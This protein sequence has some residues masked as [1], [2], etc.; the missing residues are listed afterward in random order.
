[1]STHKAIKL[2]SSLRNLVPILKIDAMFTATTTTSVGCHLSKLTIES[3]SNT[4][5]AVPGPTTTI[6]NIY[7][8]PIIESSCTV[9]TS[10]LAATILL[11]LPVLILVPL[12][13][14]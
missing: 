2:S 12:L 13:L 1:M 7:Y 5:A 3:I 9:S 11:L 14:F 8:N 10:V 4:S 6:T